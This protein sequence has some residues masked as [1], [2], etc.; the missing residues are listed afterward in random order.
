[1]NH[2]DRDAHTNGFKMGGMSQGYRPKDTIDGAK[3][4]IYIITIL[5]LAKCVAMFI[6]G[7]S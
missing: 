1:M 2:R 3:I 6:G 7:L 4:I 5:I